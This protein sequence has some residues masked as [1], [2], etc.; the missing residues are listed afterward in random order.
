MDNWYP[1]NQRCTVLSED[2]F[3][4]AKEEKEVE[5][6]EQQEQE[7]SGNR[8]SFSTWRE[9]SRRDIQGDTLKNAEFLVKLI[10]LLKLI[11]FKLQEIQI[12]LY[13]IGKTFYKY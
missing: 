8:Y 6:E 3:K 13:H 10:F 11:I 12:G 9:I 5:G 2:Q 4:K 1:S 7:I